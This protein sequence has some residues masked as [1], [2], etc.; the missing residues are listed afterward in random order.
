MLW[1]S[2][3]PLGFWPEAVRCATY[4]KN[5]SSTSAPNGKTPFEAF[6][7]SIPN[8]SHLRIFGCRCY[9]HVEK[10]HREK[11]DP[12]T[13]ECVFLG[14]YETES[15]YAV[16][17]VHHRAIMKK[18]DVV[19]YEHIMGHPAISNLGLALGYN[20]LGELCSIDPVLT[21][22]HSSSPSPNPI[23]IP[24][25]P[26]L[27]MAIP[28]SSVSSDDVSVQDIAGGKAYTL[29]HEIWRQYLSSHPQPAHS[30]T[31]QSPHDNPL[32]QRYKDHFYHLLDSL[33][34]SHNPPP[35]S[36]AVSEDDPTS[37]SAAL[38]SPN[39]SFW[40]HAAF[41]EIHQIV[42][43][44]TFDLVTEPVGRTPLPAKWVWKSKRDIHNKIE[45]FKAR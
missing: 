35:L 4:L 39:K 40:L 20:I 41:D 30:Q 16:Y 6:H 3:I 26:A 10:E 14:Y 12:H 2:Q 38:R 28:D 44:N 36:D 29:G 8:L 42:S 23:T 27:H 5:R 45:K 43:M 34:I 13:A 9:A 17:D 1:T 31:A 37:W 7:R 33:G 19:F 25:E 18:R 11:L 24:P 15:L 22:L 32:P 21:E